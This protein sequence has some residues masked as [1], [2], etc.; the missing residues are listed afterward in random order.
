MTP[1]SNATES[2]V[3]PPGNVRF[4]R[5]CRDQ[6]VIAGPRARN[7]KATDAGKHASVAF[8]GPLDKAHGLTQKAS[9]Y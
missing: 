5:E 2:P 7:T 1:R 8:N 3:L 4:N 9:R 6:S